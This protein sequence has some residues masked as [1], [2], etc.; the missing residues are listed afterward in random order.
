M[1]K[2]DDYGSIWKQ[3]HRNKM[4]MDKEGDKEKIKYDLQQNVPLKNAGHK[5]L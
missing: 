3:I 2:K 5:T 4:Y 1:N